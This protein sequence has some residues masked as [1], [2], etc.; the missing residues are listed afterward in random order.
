MVESERIKKMCVCGGGGWQRRM[1]VVVARPMMDELHRRRPRP[2]KK[3]WKR[4]E[5]SCSPGK[6]RHLAMEGRG[7]GRWDLDQDL[8]LFLRT[9]RSEIEN[10]AERGT[11]FFEWRRTERGRE[12]T[13]QK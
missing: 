1:T 3:G 8:F 10:E 4:V 5:R 9:S 12:K 6:G 7:L 13:G 11:V 2:P